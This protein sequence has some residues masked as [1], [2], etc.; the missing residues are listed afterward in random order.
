V[1]QRGH[2]DITGTIKHEINARRSARVIVAVTW[3]SEVVIT[4]D[5]NQSEVVITT[6]DIQLMS[7]SRLTVSV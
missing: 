7:P 1:V 4:T 6:D 3:E 5:D 2:H